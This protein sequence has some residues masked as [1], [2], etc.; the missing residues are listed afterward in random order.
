MKNPAVD[1]DELNQAR[2]GLGGKAVR[3]G[4]AGISGKLGGLGKL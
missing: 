2:N 3:E 1:K 4:L